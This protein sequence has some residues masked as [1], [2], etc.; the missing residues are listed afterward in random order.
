MALIRANRPST[1]AGNVPQLP[2]IALLIVIM[3]SYR[4]GPF[5]RAAVLVGIFLLLRI[6]SKIIPRKVAYDSLL[7]GLVFY[8][9]VNVLGW[10][11]GITPPLGRKLES[12]LLTSSPFFNRRIAFPF[13]SSINEIP[14]LAAAVLVAVVA[15]ISIR[16]RPRWYQWLGAAAAVFV[17]LAANNRSSIGFAVF[18]GSALLLASRATRFVAPYVVGT[19]LLAPFLVGL[20]NPLIILIFSKL[21][22][23][24][25]ARGGS[26]ANTP[27]SFEG[28][29]L[30]WAG[31][32]RFW[33]DGLPD[34]LPAASSLFFGFGADGHV[35]SGA[36]LLIPRSGSLFLLDRSYLHA[37]NSILQGLLDVGLI[38]ATMLWA[39]AVLIV[40][41]YGRDADLLP[42]FGVAVMVAM[43]GVFE[44]MLDPG[45]S[46]VPVYVLLY[47]AS[48][49]PASVGAHNQQNRRAAPMLRNMRSA[50]IPADSLAVQSASG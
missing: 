20:A 18:L 38:G 49:A 34:H 48:F 2:A 44:P 14:Y 25:I 42:I 9:V 46:F 10:M 39:V 33:T 16:R 30:V 45:F 43:A 35:K 3:L 32:S 50:S 29:Q 1:A 23:N 5:N 40:Y 31:M 6:L 37:H 36:Y 26:S 8:L 22:E 17:L 7:A 11:A 12:L 27:E 4:D 24:F 15:M 19:A 13:S 21:P 47:L 28:R 41:R